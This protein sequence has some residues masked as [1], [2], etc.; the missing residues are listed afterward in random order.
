M[1]LENII[2]IFLKGNLYK[3]DV[4]LTDNSLRILN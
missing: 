3:K 1:I 2:K 4:A